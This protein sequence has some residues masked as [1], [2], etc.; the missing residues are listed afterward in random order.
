MVPCYL[1]IGLEQ[2]RYLNKCQVDDFFMVLKFPC[3]SPCKTSGEKAQEFS[4]PILEE[5]FF[6]QQ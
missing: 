1:N 3:F 6:I 5:V 2:N 4:N